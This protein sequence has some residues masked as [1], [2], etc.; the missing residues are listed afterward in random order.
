MF[1]QLGPAVERAFVTSMP[2][3]SI[4]VPPPWGL[5]GLAGQLEQLRRSGAFA[6]QEFRR[7]NALLL[8]DG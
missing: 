8:P 2:T 5:V 1:D 4:R 7:A 6:D 3:Q